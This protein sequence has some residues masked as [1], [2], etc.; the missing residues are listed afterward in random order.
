MCKAFP[1]KPCCTRLA[2]EQCSPL[3]SLYNK[4]GAFSYF[5]SFF[6]KKFSRNTS[7]SPQP[8]HKLSIKKD[9]QIHCESFSVTIIASVTP[10][11]RDCAAA[12][13]RLIAVA[14]TVCPGFRVSPRTQPLSRSNSA[15]ISCNCSAVTSSVT[16]P[17]VSSRGHGS[18][19]TF[20]AVKR[21]QHV[22]ALGVLL[23]LDAPRGCCV[24]IP[25]H[26]VVQSD[27][28]E[29]G[30]LLLQNAVGQRTY[31]LSCHNASIS[32]RS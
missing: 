1:E 10:A 21:R 31:L 25:A 3:H 27:L 23:C 16:C 17:F 8:Y 29:L 32:S 18:A 24:L 20:R 9:P 11:A 6:F 5:F 28:P 15:S 19:Y 2:G 14:L 7:F 26:A 4:S 12:A 30:Q 22:I 13:P